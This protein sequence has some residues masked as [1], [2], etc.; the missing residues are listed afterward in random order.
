MG[1]IQ[2]GMTAKKVLAQ[3]EGERVEVRLIRYLDQ[4]TRYPIETLAD[5]ARARYASGEKATFAVIAFDDARES[6]HGKV[7]FRL[8]ESYDGTHETYDADEW[9]VVGTLLYRPNKRPQFLVETDERA[10][11]T[12]RRELEFNGMKE[13]RLSIGR[14]YNDVAAYKAHLEE[15]DSQDKSGMRTRKHGF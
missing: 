11:E 8:P 14:F 2:H 13:G 7:V 12:L 15:L 9:E 5:Q 4:D 1:V 6:L 3:L 10:V